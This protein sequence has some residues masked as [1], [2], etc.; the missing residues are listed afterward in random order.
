MLYGSW[1]TTQ[2]LDDDIKMKLVT[3]TGEREFTL[4]LEETTDFKVLTEGYDN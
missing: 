3:N 4:T 1:L 2:P